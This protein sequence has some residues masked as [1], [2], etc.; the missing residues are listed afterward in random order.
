MNTRG[1]ARLKKYSYVPVDGCDST[2]KPRVYQRDLV[3]QL[4]ALWADHDEICLASGTGSGKTLMS[5]AICE[6]L[7]K[8]NPKRRILIMA[9]GTTVIRTQ[10]FTEYSKIRPSFTFEEVRPGTPIGKSQVVIAIPQTLFRRKDLPHFYAALF[11]EAHQFSD[12]DMAV[13]IVNRCHVQK[14]LDLTAT[15]SPFVKREVPIVAFSLL[16]ALREGVIVDPL[17]ELAVSDYMLS[18]NDYNND[19]QLTDEAANKLTKNATDSTMEKVGHKLLS[20]ITRRL[21]TGSSVAG[22]LAGGRLPADLEQVYGE[23]GKSMI[24]THSI[25]QAGFVHQYLASHG[26]NCVVSDY[27]TDRDSTEIDDFK[28]NPAILALVVVN[29]GTLGFDFPGL[30][31][32]VD[33]S[34]TKNP[35]RIL[36]MLGRIVR[37]APHAKHAKHAKDKLFLKVAAE[38]MKQYQEHLVGF[39]MMLAHRETLLEWDGTDILRR[40]VPMYKD[41]D[42]VKG[43]GSGK[44]RDDEDIDSGRSQMPRPMT[45]IYLGEFFDKV[46]RDKNGVLDIYAVTTLGMVRERYHGIHARYSKQHR[47]NQFAI[48]HKRVPSGKVEGEEKLHRDYQD[49]TE[50]IG[51]H[52]VPGFKEEFKTLCNRA[53]MIEAKGSP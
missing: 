26:V 17:I 52:F 44:K 45:G 48:E 42:A 12:A 2:M 23:L 19:G 7:L 24:V 29:R 15:P 22:R 25:R 4:L 36:Q 49:L 38:K 51:A 46:A 50:T 21:R 20:M 35:N 9:H 6:A 31:A 30:G 1:S 5:A 37:V 28:T 39:T 13:D 14:R 18:L 3:D 47:L 40:P 8:G 16:D 32:L 53:M 10:I 11:D 27:S 43:A 34:E 33:L 41:E